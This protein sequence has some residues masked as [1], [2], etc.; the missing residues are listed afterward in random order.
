MKIHLALGMYR[1]KSEWFSWKGLEEANRLLDLLEAAEHVALEP[2]NKS[3]A[4]REIAELIAEHIP[5]DLWDALKANLFAAGANN[6]AAEF[7]NITGSAVAD[8]GEAA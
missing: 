7:N 4:A 6:I 1:I 5:A 3:R 8:R 2:S